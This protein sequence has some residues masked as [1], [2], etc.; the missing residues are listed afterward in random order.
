FRF[1]MPKVIPP[2]EIRDGFPPP[3]KGAWVVA[4]NYANCRGFSLSEKRGNL[5]GISLEEWVNKNI[6]AEAEKTGVSIKKKNSSKH[7]MDLLFS[8]GRYS[9]KE[10]YAK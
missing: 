3:A 4:F 7:V 5:Q 6:V 10:V 9:H 2:R 8:F 1:K